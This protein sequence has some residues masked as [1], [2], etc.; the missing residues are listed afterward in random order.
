MNFDVRY[1][2]RQGHCIA[3][4]QARFHNGLPSSCADQFKLLQKPDGSHFLDAF[5]S[6]G[7]FVSE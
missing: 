2:Q 3:H 7:I 6:I 5:R 1:T 4:H